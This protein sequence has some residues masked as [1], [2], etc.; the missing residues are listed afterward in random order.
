MLLTLGYEPVMSDQ[1]DVIYD[2]RLHT[3]TSCLREVANC[4]L[5]ILVVGSRFGGATI[6]KAL[7]MIDLEHLSDL[8]GA[9][10]FG[11]DKTN[12]SITQAEVLQA[13]Q[14]GIPVFAFIDA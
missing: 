7:E 1:A 8:S 10:R 11:A 14:T 12:I 4:D 9:D 2:P 6:P 3:H 13:I 5:V